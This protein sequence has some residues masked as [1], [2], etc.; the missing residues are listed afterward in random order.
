MTVTSRAPL[1]EESLITRL[2]LLIG[3]SFFLGLTLALLMVAAIALLLS[4]YGAEVLPYVYIVVAILGSI[5]FYGFA[6]MQ[7]RWTLMQVAFVTELL[8]VAFLALVWAGLL[9]AGADWLAFAA[10]VAFALII[11][12]GFVILGGQAGRLLD[13]RQIKQYFPRVIGGFV[14]GFTVGGALVAPL[15]SWLGGAEYL[16]LVASVSATIMLLLLVMTNLRYGDALKQTGGGGPQLPAPPLRHVLAKRFVLLIFA[17]Q[18]L[19]A[20]ASQLLDFMVMAAADARFA[21]SDILAQFFGSY[22]FFLN[23]VDLLFLVLVAGFLLSSFGLRFGLTANP[24]VDILLLVA[25]VVIGI[26]TGPTSTLFF[27]LVIMIQVLDITFADGTTRTAINAAYQALPGHERVAVQTGVEGIGVPLAL[28]LTGV[29]LLLF[30]AIGDV[31]LEDIAAFTLAISLLWLFAAFLVYRGYAANLLKTM[32]RRALDPAELTLDNQAGLAVTERLLT[33]NQLR[34][35]RLGLDI[36][37]GAEH[38][39]LS[40]HLRDLAT[41]ETA[42]IQTEALTRIEALRLQ[43]ALPIVQDLVDADI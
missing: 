41:N 43:E 5:A 14:V 27:W 40:K 10:M 25:I 21:D 9:F 1:E 13:V 23:L 22:T 6:E 39:S 36:L 34:D 11:Q 7:R 15:Q 2:T 3:Q 35:V 30:N 26:V 19:S 17:Y 16:L 31:T 12:V 33:S 29:V 28:G 8:V 37:E 42:E 32:R 24:I 4:I 20:M 18:M 38:P